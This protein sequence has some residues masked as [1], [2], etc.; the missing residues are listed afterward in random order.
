MG[1]CNGE[2]RCRHSSPVTVTMS[3][4]FGTK[5]VSSSKTEKMAGNK[6]FSIYKTLSMTSLSSKARCATVCSSHDC[7]CWCLSFQTMLD[8]CPGPNTPNY[9][10]IYFGSL[11]SFCLPMF[12]KTQK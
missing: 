9:Y 5:H 6:H 2:I 10:S 7:V 12:V 1:G 4:I 3:Q 8:T 11:V